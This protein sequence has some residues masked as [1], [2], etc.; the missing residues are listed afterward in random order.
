MNEN[1]IIYFIPLPLSF[2]VLKYVWNTS[3]TRAT[4]VRTT[5]YTSS[6]GPRT[7]E[8][9]PDKVSAVI[10]LSKL[11]G[12]L[13]SGLIPL[14]FLNLKW[15]SYR[16]TKYYMPEK[17][18]FTETIATFEGDKR[19]RSHAQKTRV[20]E[21][22]SFILTDS[23]YHAFRH[24]VRPS[25]VF[26]PVMLLLFKVVT[27]N[28]IHPTQVWRLWC[29]GYNER[30]RHLRHQSWNAHVWG[31]LRVSTVFARTGWSVRILFW[32]LWR[33]KRG[34]GRVKSWIQTTVHGFT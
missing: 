22:R 13:N 10:V 29:S 26:V 11:I 6:L 33:S 7:G 32:L 34:L 30:A 18:L 24:Q 3:F 28:H 12:D 21:R 8:G 25:Q 27:G 14:R 20:S 9:L 2:S 19:F 23:L 4:E 17:G 5:R 1:F 15:P 16:V 31:A